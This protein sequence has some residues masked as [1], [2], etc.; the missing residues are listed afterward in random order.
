MLQLNQIP[1]PKLLRFLSNTENQSH[2]NSYSLNIKP[3]GSKQ[4]L[5]ITAWIIFSKR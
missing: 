4:S 5:Q 1:L 2:F 3:V